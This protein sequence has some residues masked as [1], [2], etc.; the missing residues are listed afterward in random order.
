ML[1]QTLETE[2]VTHTVKYTMF[3]TINICISCIMVTFWK[4]YSMTRQRV[5]VL[6]YFHEFITIQGLALVPL[7]QEMIISVF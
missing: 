7:D 4:K 5:T 1:R 6:H 3:L 2:N